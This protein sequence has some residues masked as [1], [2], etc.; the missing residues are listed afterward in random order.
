MNGHMPVPRK[1]IYAGES[2]LCLFYF[3]LLI[4]VSF[5]KIVIEGNFNT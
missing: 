1:I 5:L 3:I 4:E 2:V